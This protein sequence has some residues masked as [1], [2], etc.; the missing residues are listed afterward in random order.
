MPKASPVIP[1]GMAAWRAGRAPL[2]TR[3]QAGG[4]RDPPSVAGLADAVPPDAAP[5]AAR[6]RPARFTS[7]LALMAVL[8]GGCEAPGQQS[9]PRANAESPRRIVQDDTGAD[10][11]I[12]VLPSRVACLAPDLT[13]IVFEVGA[14]EAVVA[15]CDPCDHPPQ[16]AR[17]PRLGPMI[18]PSIEAILLIRPDLVL[19][20]GEGNPLA[21][22]RRLREMGVAVVGLDPGPGL[23]GVAAQVRRVGDLVGHGAQAG[24][25]ADDME[26]RWSAQRARS[27]GARRL[28]ACIL[29]WTDPL[30]A[31]G[32]DSYLTEL[33]DLAGADNACATKP[34]WPTLSREDVLLARPE[35]VLLGIA[36][37]SVTLGDWAASLPALR[38]QAVL[39]LPE[40]PFLR[41]TTGLGPAAEELWLL[42]E[43]HRLEGQG[44]P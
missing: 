21:V 38:R 39:H 36:D 20:T 31:A 14:G 12:P 35:I 25:L 8:L 23:A 29:V 26:A 1:R 28:R 6:L 11:S 18:E 43:P 5:C 33:A 13:E 10:V 17:L 19:A 4:L 34:G 32:S 40:R 9:N 41:P 24:R 3:R 44:S 15:A 16:A 2:K 7:G 42:L 22:V 30:V 27:A 37:R